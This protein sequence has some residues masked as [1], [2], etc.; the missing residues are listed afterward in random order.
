[1][2]PRL[3]WQEQPPP[4]AS[5]CP[6]ISIYIAPPPTPCRPPACNAQSP[7][8]LR[9]Q[10][11]FI[12]HN[13][14]NVN[15]TATARSVLQSPRPCPLSILASSY[16]DDLYLHFH[17]TQSPYKLVIEAGFINHNNSSVMDAHPRVSRRQADSALSTSININ[18]RELY[19]L[20]PHLI[21]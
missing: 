15:R 3:V 2:A 19:R 13:H 1:M 8:I 7:Y 9:F 16:D 4:P 12:Y 10:P 6:L 17:W 14:S 21:S 5:S 20:S 11:T 18:R